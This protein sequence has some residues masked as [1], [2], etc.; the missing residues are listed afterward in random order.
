MITEYALKR[1]LSGVDDSQQKSA[2]LQMSLAHLASPT[3]SSSSSCDR[4][5]GDRQCLNT[6]IWVLFNI[7]FLAG[8]NSKTDE[9]NTDSQERE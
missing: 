3:E 5:P 8:A 7:W 9:S 6:S 1:P 4:E 2:L